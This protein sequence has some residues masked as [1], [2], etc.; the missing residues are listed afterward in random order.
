[1]TQRAT[2]LPHILRMLDSLDGIC[3][4]QVP[5]TVRKFPVPTQ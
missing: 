5:E 4:K 1:M 2:H 3:R